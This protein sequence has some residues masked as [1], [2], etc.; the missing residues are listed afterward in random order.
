MAKKLPPVRLE[1]VKASAVPATTSTPVRPAAQLAGDSQLS[2][3][4]PA[5]IVRQVKERAAA[6][7]ETL[8]VTVL[9]ALAANGF[10]IA[11]E[12]LVDRR[13]EAA[14]IKGELYRRFKAEQG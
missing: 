14:R 5:G 8:R 4:L 9:R 2:V 6:Q 13:I 7:G 10:D 3:M 1:E 12:D 11:D